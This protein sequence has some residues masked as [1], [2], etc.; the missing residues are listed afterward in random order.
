MENLNKQT[1][2]YLRN[3]VEFYE[4]RSR[5]TKGNHLLKVAKIKLVSSGDLSFSKYAQILWNVLPTS[6]KDTN[7]ISRFKSYLKTRLLDF[8]TDLLYSAFPVFFSAGLP[9]IGT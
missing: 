2:H 3:R 5:R 1:A 4:D 6:M 8:L 9:E 7:N